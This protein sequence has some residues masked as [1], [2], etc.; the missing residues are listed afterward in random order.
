MSFRSKGKGRTLE[1]KVTV[2]NESVSTYLAQ[3]NTEVFNIA[4]RFVMSNEQYVVDY[5]DLHAYRILSI[6]IT[7]ITL[8]PF[9]VTIV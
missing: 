9:Q 1:V 5:W 7:Y 6:V 3:G 4:N 2:Q 8:T